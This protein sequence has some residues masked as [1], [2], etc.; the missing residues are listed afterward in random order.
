MAH[1]PIYTVGTCEFVDPRSTNSLQLQYRRLPP[2]NAFT[3]DRIIWVRRLAARRRQRRARLGVRP[4][5]VLQTAPAPHSAALGRRRCIALGLRLPVRRPRR[6]RPRRSAPH[7]VYKDASPMCG[8]AVSRISPRLPVVKQRCYEKHYHVKI[9]VRLLLLLCG[10]LRL[11]LLAIALGSRA[12][13][14][15]VRVVDRA[16]AQAIGATHAPSARAITQASRCSCSCC[17]RPNTSTR[18]TRRKQAAL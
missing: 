2:K 12:V 3:I 1:L 9:K 15:L 6:R 4:G 14:R 13:D 11:C 16:C 5:R 7:N 17:S 8:R 18:Q 10:Y